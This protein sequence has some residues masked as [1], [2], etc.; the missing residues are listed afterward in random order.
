LAEAIAGP[1]R[2]NLDKAYAYHLGL[3]TLATL[4]A[5]P[6]EKQEA[7]FAELLT[8]WQSVSPKE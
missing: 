1:I 7:K 8:H 3:R 5:Q 4:A 6:P 2:W